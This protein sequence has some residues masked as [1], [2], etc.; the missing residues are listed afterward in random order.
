MVREPEKLRIAD[1]RSAL[2][3]E[4]ARDH[5][6]HLIEQQLLRD[7]TEIQERV[8]EA[9]DRRERSRCARRQPLNRGSGFVGSRST[10][11]RSTVLVV[12]GR[13][14]HDRGQPSRSR[15]ISVALRQR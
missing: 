14:G 8:L 15:E 11:P 12:T 13:G 10:G 2:Q 3:S 4:V 5:H 7:A 6:L 9:V 1:Q